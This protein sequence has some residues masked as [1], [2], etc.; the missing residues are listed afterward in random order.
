MRLY[1]TDQPNGDRSAEL[2]DAA[3]N[4][5]NTLL[6]K[7]QADWLKAAL[8]RSTA[9]WNVLAQ[10]VMMGLVDLAAGDV[11]R[12]SMDHW[13]SAAFERM[14]LMQ[15]IAERR[16]PNP[17]VLTGNIHSNWVNELR[18]DD[19]K[20]ETGVVATEF[21]GTSISSRG[22]GVKEV[23]GLDALLAENPFV[24]YHN[25]QRGYVRCTVKPKSWKSDYQ[26]VE[27]VTK[28]GTPVATGASFVVEA[29]RPGVRP[30]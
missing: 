26:I 17:V 9:T 1:R 30:A 16:V 11:T 22:N 5:Q 27:D 6:G 20:M 2:N 12:Y 18:V 19:R 24:K 13:P 4:P 28:P 21:V 15:W 29:G 8:L 10:Q 7:P 3:P 25:R 14:K 23:K